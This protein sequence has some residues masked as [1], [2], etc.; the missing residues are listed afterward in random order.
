MPRGEALN[1]R[2]AIRDRHIKGAIAELVFSRRLLS[3][4]EMSKRFKL[5]PSS[6]FLSIREPRSAREAPKPIEPKGVPLF[7][8]V[9]ELLASNAFSEEDIKFILAE[10]AHGRGPPSFD[11]VGIDKLCGGKVLLDVKCVGVEIASPTLSPNQR[12]VAER[13]KA[14]GFDVYVALLK[15]EQDW[16]VTMRLIR[17]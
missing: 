7:A 1:H 12:K 13:A 8:S 16:S 3:H 5:L 6:D 9:E 10:V 11:Y 15:L 4:P 2:I 14:L 17:V